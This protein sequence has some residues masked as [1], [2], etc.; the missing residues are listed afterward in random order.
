MKIGLTGGTG[1][2][3][4]YVLK[5]NANEHEFV[6]VTSRD[7]GE[8]LF[9]HPNVKYVTVAYNQSEFE[10]AFEGCDAVVHLG[11]KRSSKEAE[12]SILNYTDNL[13]VSEDLFKACVNLNIKNIVNISSYAVYDT[14]L[15]LPFEESLAVSPLSNYGV[16]KHTIESLAHLYNRKYA[17]NI[18]SLR[19][20]QVIGVGERGGY[21]LS[22]FLE[23]C[24][25]QQAL[26]VYGKGVAGREYVY[27]KDVSK[28]V[29]CALKSE[30]TKEVFNIGN[31]FITTNLELAQ[32][33][34]KVFDNKAGCICLEDKKEIVEHYLMS[35]ELA[36]KELGFKPD[37]TLE[38]ALSDM[39]GILENR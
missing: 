27:V 30:T 13:R 20:A 26:N 36:E 4:Q 10:K 23:R 15:P 17:M 21:M 25:N 16:M 38:G 19:L 22:I 37:Y 3:G 29:M 33:F 24:L 34:C 8:G 12:E 31:G 11:A 28:A 35:G 5:E 6:V 7:A 39:K 2:I 14:T 18:K 9:V 1:F 32:A